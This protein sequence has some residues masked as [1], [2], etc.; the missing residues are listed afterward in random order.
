MPTARSVRSLGERRVRP[1]LVTFEWDGRNDEG[2]IV[3]DGPYRLKVEFED[4]RRTIVI[5]NRI[6]VDTVPPEVVA[7]A[8]PIPS[9]SPL[10]ETAVPTSSGSRIGQTGQRARCCTSVTSSRSRGR[11]VAHAAPSSG[12]AP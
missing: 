9:R 7:H 8:E 4:K 11:L 3:P 10:T 5:P 1:G 2:R 12:T 6:F